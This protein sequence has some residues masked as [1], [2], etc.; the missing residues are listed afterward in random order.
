MGVAT[1]AN[2]RTLFVRFVDCDKRFKAHSRLI[3]TDWI[4]LRVAQMPRSQ[5]LMIFVVTTDGQTDGL[6]YPRA[7]A[8]G[9]ETGKELIPSITLSRCALQ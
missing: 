3:P 9:N 2:K 1:M 6:L 4:R 8:R 7:C 5:D